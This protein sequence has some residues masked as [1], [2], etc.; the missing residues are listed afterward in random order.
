VVLAINLT[1]WLREPASRSRLLYEARVGAR[2]SRG[3]SSSQ[4]MRAVARAM[5]SQGRLADAMRFSSQLDRQRGL[6]REERFQVIHD[7]LTS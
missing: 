7:L 6:A 1:G 2:E 4:R 3:P 5:R